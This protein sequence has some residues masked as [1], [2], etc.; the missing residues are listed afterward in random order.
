MKQQKQSVK[1]AAVAQPEPETIAVAQPEPETIAVRLR[2]V[3]GEV[4][5]ASSGPIHA[6]GNEL[7]VNDKRIVVRQ[8]W[9]M[10]EVDFLPVKY[11]LYTHYAKKDAD[12]FKEWQKNPGGT[13]LTQL[14]GVDF[15]IKHLKGL[16]ELLTWPAHEGLLVLFYG[17]GF[18][19]CLDGIAE[20]KSRD[21]LCDEIPELRFA[22]EAPRPQGGASNAESHPNLRVP[23]DSAQ[24]FS[25]LAWAGKGQ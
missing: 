8:E 2:V 7:R 23:A 17:P 10:P 9:A 4:E 25:T 11:V 24:E 20:G 19:D 6:Q 1:K 3:N 21:V 13:N 14:T 5:L 22:S 18:P 16:Q 12:D 15:L